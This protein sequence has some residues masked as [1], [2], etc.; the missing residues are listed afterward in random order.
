MDQEKER[1]QL[2]KEVLHNECEHLL[3]FLKLDSNKYEANYELEVPLDDE[4]NFVD[5]VITIWKKG[6][7]GGRN[8]YMSGIILVEPY[9][10][11]PKEVLQDINY[12]FKHC[13]KLYADKYFKL[14]VTREDEF[15]DFFTKA[16]VDV[17][18][19]SK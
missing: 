15:T 9:F 10:D 13:N 12:C 18:M 3:S 7:L 19:Y 1:I 2:T 5:V 4:E 17:L 11:N 16:G 14:L 6:I 8:L